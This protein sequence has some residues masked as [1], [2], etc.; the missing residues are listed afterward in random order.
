M[1]GDAS[2]YRCFVWWHFPCI[3][4]PAVYVC[5]SHRDMCAFLEGFLAD[6]SSQVVQFTRD[7]VQV[8]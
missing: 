5:E 2:T 8:V 1:S 4:G 6:G 3:H 7:A